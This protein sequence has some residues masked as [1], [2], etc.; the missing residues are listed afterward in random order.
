MTILVACRDCGAVWQ[1]P[2]PPKKGWVECPNCGR[3]LEHRTGR[4]LDG[5]LACAVTTFVLL[6]PANY[7]TLM[8]VHIGSIPQSTHLLSGIFILWPQGLQFAAI[9]LALCGIVL[10]FARFGLL[11]VAL[12]AIQWGVRET[13]V[14]TTFRY[15]ELLDLWAMPDVLLIGAGIGY[16]RVASQTRVDIDPG[17]WCI[18]GAALMTMLTRATLDSRAVWRRLEIPFWEAGPDAVACTSCDFVLPAGQDGERCPRCTARVHRRRPGSMV[19]CAALAAATAVLTP[20]AYSYPMSQ[21]WKAGTPMTNNIINGIQMLFTHGFWYFGIMIFCVSVVFP[22]TKL[23]GLTWF[24]L[25]IRFGWSQ[26][27]RFKSGLY[28][29]I[30]EIGR[31]SLLDPFTV[32]V[33]TPMIRLG[34]LAHFTAMIGTDAFLATVVLSMLA[35]LTLDPRLLWDLAEVQGARARRSSAVAR[36]A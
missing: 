7:L 28:R 19:Q 17:G 1:L 29:F 36:P 25:S 13:W 15:A 6:F 11:S 27:L 18:V 31:W 24:L 30:D 12:T 34:Q 32:M 16:G 8:T 23:G 26:H 4:S 9:V 2:P 5:A 10:P 33:F 22:L 3:I 14:G 21:F 35:S 20:I